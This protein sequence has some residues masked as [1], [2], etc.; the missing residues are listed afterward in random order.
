MIWS[1]HH[2][3]SMDRIVPG[4]LY[5]K[6][7]SSNL[8]QTVG[9]NNPTPGWRGL[10]GFGVMSMMGG[11]FLSLCSGKAAG[12]PQTPTPWLQHEHCFQLVGSCPRAQWL[13]AYIKTT[14]KINTT[15]K[16]QV[17]ILAWD[18][19]TLFMCHS[20][21][22][23]RAGKNDGNTNA[24]SRHLALAQLLAAWPQDRYRQGHS[25]LQAKSA[26]LM[27]PTT[28]LNQSSNSQCF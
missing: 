19:V 7:T 3:V 25:V 10:G 16:K 15:D 9:W 22:V 8:E 11:L 6:T 17:K 13:E 18:I 24:V 12:N 27:L 1:V 4:F 2:L 23:W 20:Q 21:W 5:V 28:V 26:G 14:S